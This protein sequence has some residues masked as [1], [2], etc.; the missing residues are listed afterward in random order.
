MKQIVS[1]LLI[2]PFLLLLDGCEDR[3]AKEDILS[4]VLEKEESILNCIETGDYTALEGQ[5]PIVEISADDDCTDFYCGGSG[6]ASGSMY[7]GFFY[8]KEDDMKAIWCAPSLPEHTLTPC[9]NGYIWKEVWTD[10]GG[11]NTYYVEK[12][13]ENIFY[14]E[15]C[16]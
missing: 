11:D 9:D 16:F 6:F 8:T 7:V 14:Y 5:K 15:A 13:V 3:A 12:I 2:L 1:V 4:F 10:E